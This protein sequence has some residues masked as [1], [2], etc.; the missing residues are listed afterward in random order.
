MNDSAQ[1]SAGRQPS[2][3][4]R[5]LYSMGG[6]APAARQALIGLYTLYLYTTVM[7]LPATL[8]GLA[9]AIGLAWE[10]LLAPYVGSLFDRAGGRDRG[11]YGLMLV[12]GLALGV[13]F[14]A[15]MSPPQGLSTMGLFLWLLIS[16]LAVRTATNLFLIPYLA[17][18]AAL[19]DDYHQR[20][21]VS[22]LRGLL[23]M[24]GAAAMTSL[25]FLLFFPALEGGIDPKLRYEGYGAMGLTFGVLMAVLALVATYGSWLGR[26]PATQATE[27]P[28]KTAATPLQASLAAIRNP[29]FAVL[30]TACALFFLGA[31]ISRVLLLH[32]LT[33][34][35]EIVDSAS[36]ALIQAAAFIGSGVGLF[37]AMR[38]LRRWE[39][40]R[41]LA[42]GSLA[43]GITMLSTFLCIGEGRLFG[44]DNLPAVMLL[45]SL[46]SAFGGVYFFIPQSMLA[47]VVDQDTLASGERR[48]GVYF[49]SFAMV[50][51][52]T[53]GVALLAGGVLADHYAGLATG[54]AEVS[55]ATAM[56]ISLLYAVLPGALFLAAGALV[57]RYGLGRDQVAA[58][59]DRLHRRQRV[60]TGG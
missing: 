30:A 56:R 34:Q 6:A 39:K 40:Q 54:V 35:A 33:F 10:A 20:S 50:Q 32:F 57:T 1:R 59:Q 12:G 18:G 47:D 3:P 41:V 24:I 4:I 31:V 46:A 11:R 44:T 29:S 52:A 26:R 21:V 43:L 48:G 23:S 42:L 14:W 25:S 19:T 51:R 38:A 55:A 5:L 22:W 15:Y 2:V 28:E 8:V 17:V 53:T 45:A 27:R 37:I 16:S 7:G 36:L 13:S 60:D 49:G 9:T 58:V